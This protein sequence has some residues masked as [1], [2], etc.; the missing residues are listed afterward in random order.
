ML[1]QF[2][3]P[4]VFLAVPVVWTIVNAVRGIS[5]DKWMGNVQVLMLCLYTLVNSAVNKC[6]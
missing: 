5:E 1:T 2:S 3:S 4:M 6:F